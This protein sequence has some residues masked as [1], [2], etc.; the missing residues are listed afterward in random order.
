MKINSIKASN[1]LSFASEEPL[2]IDFRK[3]GNI[4]SI[5]GENRDHGEHASNGAGKSTIIEAVVYA[6]YGSL[7]KNLNH[8]EA[9]NIKSKGKL[10][11]EIDFDI[12]GHNYLIVRKRGK[13]SSD[14]SLT[15]FKDGKEEKM[16]K[17][18]IADGDML[19]RFVSATNTNLEPKTL[20]NVAKELCSENT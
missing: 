15:V 6:L 11:V 5:R 8:T 4:V 7:I 19:E 12:D 17:F 1:F 16:K 9:I 10:T 13:G 3:L 18:N 2:Y 14:N 20:L